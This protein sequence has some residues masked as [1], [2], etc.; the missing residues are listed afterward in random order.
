M[1]NPIK[2]PITIPS[3]IS[4]RELA[5]R[6]N[7][8]ASRIIAQ[9]MKSGMFATINEEIDFDTASLI[10]E[11]MGFEAKQEVV[12]KSDLDSKKGSRLSALGGE[13]VGGG[14]V[15]RPP[16]VTILG[17][18]DHGKTTL[19][20][21]IRKTHVAEGEAGG[22]T[23]HISSYQIEVEV[24]GRKELITFLDTPGHEA[25]TALRQRGANITDIAIIIIAADDGVMPQT[26]EAI[27][28]AQKAGV[29]MIIAVNKIDKPGANVA[30]IKQQLAEKNVLVEG[31][32]GDVPIVEISAKNKI[33][34]ENLLEVIL[35]VADMQE[36]KANPSAPA[37]GVVL[38]SRL[39]PQKG[40]LAVLI[41]LE[42]T[43]KKG[44]EVIAG[45]AHGK[46]KKIEDFKGAVLKE[47]GP[48]SPIVIMGMK[49]APQAGEIITV[50]QKGISRSKIAELL[51]EKKRT[52]IGK[53]RP[54]SSDRIFSGEGK[55]NEFNIVLKA[56]VPGSLEAIMGSIKKIDVPNLKINIIKSG[57]GN[58]NQDDIQTAKSSNSLILGF[59]ITVNAAVRKLA[60]RENVV[61]HTH[62]I[63]YELIDDLKSSISDW[64]GPETIRTQIG[65][66]KIIA[67]FGRSKNAQIIGGKIT[68]GK[69][70]KD[71]I[72]EVEREK[73]K[74]GEG[75]IQEV[76][77]SKEV[78]Q[79]AVEGSECGVKF[80]GNVEIKEGD[81]LKFNV[82]EERKRTI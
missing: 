6:L 76:R 49:E 71:S 19:L 14:S 66:M 10:L 56:D 74:V 65:T 80:V 31:W 33:G 73:Q 72:A 58:L 26:E 43:L 70:R 69:I 61:I 47:A 24:K 57:I 62:N 21:T 17:H 81:V 35:L 4:V 60:E 2:K 44:D 45:N 50:E 34:I 79:E 1:L 55:V 59:D 53:L 27:S 13:G 51:E 37:R 36:I 38:D 29:P 41:I 22:I 67:L 40:P 15:K 42:G 28:L 7:M 12:I 25:F 23:Q 48:S 46:V 63:I 18:V 11:E 20:D 3:S 9:L 78:I 64:L 5:F 16:I 30:R 32:G 77:I 8:P 82:E 75:T 68:S 39:D 52:R 54:L